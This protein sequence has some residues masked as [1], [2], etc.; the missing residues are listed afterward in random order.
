[1]TEHQGLINKLFYASL[2]FVAILGIIL[3]IATLLQPV[4]TTS[5]PLVYNAFFPDTIKDNA[6]RY[7][8]GNTFVRYDLNSGKT[9]DLAPALTRPIEN[10]TE[11]YWLPDA[12]VFTART[13]PTWSPLYASFQ[14]VPDRTRE[15]LTV[16]WYLPFASPTPEILFVATTPPPSPITPVGDKLLYYEKLSLKTIGAG[17]QITAT[18]KL[19]DSMEGYVE[20][21][22]IDDTAAYY[23][24]Y[25]NKN[26]DL[27]RYDLK[28]R[29]NQMIEK[30][31]AAVREPLPILRTYMGDARHLVYFDRSG[32]DETKHALKSIDLTTHKRT[33]HIQPFGGSLTKYGNTLSAVYTAKSNLL[34]YTIKDGQL[35]QTA[36][37]DDDYS[38]PYQAQCQAS[39]CYYFEGGGVIRLVSNDRDK[40]SAAKAGYYDALEDKIKSDN[41][42][43]SR[44]V[45]SFQDN[46]YTL[47]M[48]DGKLED[49]YRQAREAVRAGG[50]DP[51]QA[52]FIVTPGRFVEY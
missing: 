36:K 39:E 13:V 49:R 50:R 47:T 16:Y 14:S 31:L 6:M 34:F 11:V 43:L 22:F 30:S 9:T 24:L 29:K 5:Q 2:G 17:K 51:L 52:T 12:V 44:S 33:T 21:L 40:L 28:D 3:L 45:M 27:L 25:T 32:D 7:Y 46:S 23:L 37:I 19:A 42:S 8:N 15:G 35:S 4:T 10:L 26:A 48:L 18:P 1:M 41:F 38:I 20:P